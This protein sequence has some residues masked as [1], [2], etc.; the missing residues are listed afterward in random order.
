MCVTLKLLLAAT[1]NCK[2]CWD[3][4]VQVLLKERSRSQFTSA[5]T[6]PN[7]RCCSA[8]PA[9][10]HLKV[11]MC[12]ETQHGANSFTEDES[13]NTSSEQARCKRLTLAAGIR[14][15]HTIA[16]DPRIAKHGWL[17]RSDQRPAEQDLL[18][19]GL[20]WRQQCLQPAMEVDAQVHTSIRADDRVTH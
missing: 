6:R 8:T 15:I 13:A 7:V 18:M 14:L 19:A 4:F 3:V 1:L 16:T 12:V 17:G 9:Q 20:G 11:F 5:S 10:Q 2:A